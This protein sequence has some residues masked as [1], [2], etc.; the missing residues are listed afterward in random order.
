MH[1]IGTPKCVPHSAA[2]KFD[3]LD[4]MYNKEDG[5]IWDHPLFD[6]MGRNP[7]SVEKGSAQ[8]SVPVSCR[9]V[10]L[11]RREKRFTFEAGCDT[12]VQRGEIMEK[13][14]KVALLTGG[15]SGIGLCTAQALYQAGCAVYEI[16]RRP[17]ETPGVCHIFG[18]VTDEKSVEA[19][20]RQVV[21]AEGRIDILVNNAGFGISGA[22]EFTDTE[23]AKRQ[24]DVNFFGMVRVCRAVLPHMRGAGSGRI[25][26]VSSVAAAIP[27]PF[28]TFYSASKA[29]INSYSMALANEVRPYGITVCAVM[30]GDIRTGFTAA[31]KKTALGDE[32]YGGRVS[33]S[34][35]KMEMDEQK[36][37][38]PRSAGAFVARTALR[39]SVKPLYAIRLDYKFFVLLSRLLPVR[40]LNVLVYRLYAK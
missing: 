6:F 17:G 16:S 34:V 1:P 39:R 24:F 2:A 32:S 37:M 31:R 21:E 20:V 11:S 25:V 36:G 7:K 12:M 26:N 30:P 40:A 35:M 18:D 23:D 29:A 13:Q 3:C 4:C 27:I 22:V 38:P 5:L 10:D 15:S 9:R 19:A 14:K 33:R 28:Q 8:R